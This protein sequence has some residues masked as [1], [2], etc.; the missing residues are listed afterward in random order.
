MT[1]DEGES[2]QLWLSVH[3]VP[4]PQPRPRFVKG[5][6]V[7]TANKKV[8]LWRE[9][10]RRAVR[11][12]VERAGWRVQG[13]R[14]LDLAMTFRMPPSEGVKGK[15]K[16]AGA[17]ATTRPDADNLAKLVMD[18]MQEA[19]AFGHGNDPDALVTSLT[20]RK[21]WAGG[22]YPPG[23][24]IRLSFDRASDSV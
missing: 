7:S 18:M 8:G 20:V 21:L 3:G 22:E 9:G 6:A 4:R 5:V 19:G 24:T 16:V 12:A 13:D 1:D 10:V 17:P 23:V 2:D 14:G 15:G 11:E